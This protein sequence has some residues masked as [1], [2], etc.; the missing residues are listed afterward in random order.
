MLPASPRWNTAT[1]IK[2]ETP[3]D[4]SGRYRSTLPNSGADNPPPCPWKK[5]CASQP[6]TTTIR[7]GATATV[8]GQPARIET[9]DNATREGATGARRVAAATATA[10]T[11]LTTDVTATS[12]ATCATNSPATAP[13][14]PAEASNDRAVPAFVAHA[15]AAGTAKVEHT[16]SGALAPPKRRA[17]KEVNRNGRE[18]HPRP[19]QVAT[20]ATATRPYR[21]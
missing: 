7:L 2:P 19:P 17:R 5:T 4:R 14:T 18:P 21:A 9:T 20:L 10:T 1:T 15:T 8:A 16:M 11:A 6:S 13:P 12:T 3:T